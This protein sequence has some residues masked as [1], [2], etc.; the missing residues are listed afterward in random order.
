MFDLSLY[1]LDIAYNSIRAQ[2]KNLNIMIE[3]IE[4]INRLTI[5]ILDDGK[6]IKKENLGNVTSPFYTTRDTRKVGLGLPFIKEIANQANGDIEILSEENEYTKVKIWM[7]YIHIDRPE[8][9]DLSMTIYN[10]CLN[11]ILVNFI[12][13]FNDQEFIFKKSEVLEILDGVPLTEYQIMKYIRSYIKDNICEVK[14]DTK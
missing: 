5:E 2:A 1:I 14:G 8:L 9:G 12:F 3:I 6:G 10:L 11:D 7:D 13:R 4:K